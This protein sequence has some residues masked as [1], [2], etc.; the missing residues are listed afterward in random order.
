MSELS[1]ISSPKKTKV[2]ETKVEET[3]NNQL[4]KY[5]NVEIE[6]TN[7]KNKVDDSIETSTIK[8]IE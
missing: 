2:E 7:F 6:T 5:D 4:S 8:S 1:D 3:Q